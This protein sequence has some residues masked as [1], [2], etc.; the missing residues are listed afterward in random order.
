MN[1]TQKTVLIVLAVISIIVITAGGTY[2]FFTA[3]TSSNSLST[4]IHEL[5]VV[6]EGDTEING[7]LELTTD[8]SGGHRREISIGLAE[9]SVGAKA[10]IFIHHNSQFVK[11]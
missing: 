5:D 11:G 8:K 2:A 3:I 1:K 7:N 9:H 4:N 6:Y 10:N